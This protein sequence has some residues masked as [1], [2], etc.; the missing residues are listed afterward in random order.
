VNL[1]LNI[2]EA[3]D[4]EAWQR[5]SS[6]IRNGIFYHGTTESAANRILRVGFHTSTHGNEIHNVLKKYGTTYNDLTPYRRA[7]VRRM[8]Q[9]RG[10]DY[11]QYVSITHSPEIARRWA[12][13][14]G[15]YRGDVERWAGLS[16]NRQSSKF[17]GQKPAILRVKV[18]EHGLNQ[19]RYK[20]LLSMLYR[21]EKDVLNGE[22]PASTAYEFLAN[23]YMELRVKPDE[24]LAVSR[25]Q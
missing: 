2:I 4:N 9:G 5:L 7:E 6:D 12:G 21:Y 22:Y 24:I 13:H 1:L 23:H 19:A 15:E 11:H 8:M 10:E 25:Y 14:G 17:K 3:I 16:P 20:H 18:N